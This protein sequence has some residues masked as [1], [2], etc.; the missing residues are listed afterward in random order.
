MAETNAP[1]PADPTTAFHTYAI[2]WFPKTCAGQI[3]TPRGTAYRYDGDIMQGPAAYPSIHP[4]NLIINLW[5]NSDPYFSAGPPV[6]DAVVTI[7]KVTAY[8]DKPNKIA[9]GA[10]VQQVACTPATACSV[11]I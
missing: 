10:C 1:F 6:N 9:N 2:G 4:S 8:Y 3:N 5:T 11:N 7:K